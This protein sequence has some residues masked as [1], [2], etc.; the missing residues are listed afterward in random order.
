MSY[1]TVYEVSYFSSR[2]LLFGLAVFVGGVVF[3]ASSLVVWRQRKARRREVV[4]GVFFGSIWI[5]FS[6][7]WAWTNLRAGWILMS[8]L[9]SG[10]CEVTE[11]TVHVLSQQP[12]VGHAGGDRGAIAPSWVI[13]YDWAIA[14][15]AAC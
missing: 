1:H 11:G 6:L 5:L 7:C 15:P 2:E 10:R 14:I 13:W 12:R 4:T 8:I 3:T 9:R